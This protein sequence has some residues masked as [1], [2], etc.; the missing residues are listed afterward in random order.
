MSKSLAEL[1]AAWEWSSAR[2]PPTEAEIEDRRT[3]YADYYV[4]GRCDGC[5]GGACCPPA[6]L[7]QTQSQENE[8]IK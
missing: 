4:E 8:V 7:G 2:N 1:A 6:R 5:A 3:N